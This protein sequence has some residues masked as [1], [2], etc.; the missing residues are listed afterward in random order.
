MCA[1]H[2]QADEAPPSKMAADPVGYNITWT[3]VLQVTVGW[4]A[5]ILH[6]AGAFFSHS[7]GTHLVNIAR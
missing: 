2:S 6:A 3:E 5:R 7:Q 4:I 1:F